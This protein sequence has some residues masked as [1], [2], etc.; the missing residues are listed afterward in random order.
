MRLSV[1]RNDLNPFLACLSNPIFNYYV[2]FYFLSSLFHAFT[3]LRNTPPARIR[4]RGPLA[5]T[6]HQP[7]RTTSAVI[8]ISAVEEYAFI[9]SHRNLIGF[10]LLL[11]IY[12]YQYFI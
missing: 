3:F 2:D 9:Y 11:L 10:Q 6:A 7:L 4:R 8:R 12:I 5:V 1:F